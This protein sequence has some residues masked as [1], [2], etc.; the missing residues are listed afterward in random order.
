MELAGAELVDSGIPPKIRELGGKQSRLLFIRKEN[1]DIP[2]SS[3]AWSLR[4]LPS[5]AVH[6]LGLSQL[7]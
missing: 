6:A 2:L 4:L 5:K 7:F 3:T 1:K